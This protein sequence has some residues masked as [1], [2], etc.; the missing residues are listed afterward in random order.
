M[1]DYG[2]RNYDPALGRWMNIDPKAE[3]SRRWTP[4]NYAY[5][6]PMFFV[7][8]DGMQADGWITQMVDGKKSITYNSTVNTVEEAKAAGYEGA[9]AVNTALNVSSEDGSYSYNLNENGSVTDA[10][11]NKVDA[12]S[13]I[14][15][16]TGAGTKISSWGLQPT[17]PSASG[18]ANEMNLTSPFFSWGWAVKGLG[19][20]WNSAFGTAA[21]TTAE[22]S[23]SVYSVA[24]ETT[25]SSELFPGGSYYSHFKAANTS[26]SN[27]MASD[28]VFSQSMSNLGISVPRSATGN[29]LGKSPANWVWH[30]DVG[31]GVM[32]LVPKT[33][34]TTGS[35]FWETLHPGGVG[36]MFLWNK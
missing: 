30:H 11:G 19:Y 9:T 16:T 15:I 1:Y 17:P 5:N 33:Q 22:A 23:G 3:N 4:Y 34:H 21:S 12:T 36:G 7:D 6:N 28:A 26:L 8:P 29:I 20:A 13:G 32:Q 25:L 14:S 2:A 31:V 35:M 10:E 24:Y 18:A 27:S